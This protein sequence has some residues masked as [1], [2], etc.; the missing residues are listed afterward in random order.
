MKAVAA[1]IGTWDQATIQALESQGRVKIVVGGDEVDIFREDVQLSTEDIPGM[2][3]HSENGLT[4]ALDITL[5]EELRWEGLAR[6]LVNRIQNLRKDQ[7]LAVTDR[8]RLT[9]ELEEPLAQ[10]A[11]HFESYL[12]QETLAEEVDYTEVPEALLS[13]EIDGYA[14]RI[15]LRK[16]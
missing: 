10:A 11:R 1:A 2:L 14:L 5:T 4:V 16:S 9:M 13:D 6:E 3:V 12:K 7:H 15:S 8:I